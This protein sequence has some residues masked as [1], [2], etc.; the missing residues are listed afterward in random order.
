ML[1]ILA[2][3][4]SGPMQA[5]DRI[6]FRQPANSWFEAVPVGNG[7][8]GAMVFGGVPEERLQL[9]EDTVWAGKRM[10]RV[11][12]EGRAAVTKTRQLLKEGKIREAEEAAQAMLA[13]PV[14]MPPYQPL[15]DLK[16][17]FAHPGTPSAYAR[18]L[19]LDTAIA[20]TVYRIADTTYTREV[21][22]SYPSQAIVVRLSASRQNK[23]SF[24]VSMSRENA[25]ATAAGSR[26]TL[27]GMAMPV[28]ERSA[29]EPKTGVRFHAVT[30]VNQS[31][32]QIAVEG[33]TVLVTNAS[34]ATLRVVAATDYFAAPGVDWKVKCQAA[35]LRSA[36]AYHTLRAR[37]VEDYQRL[38]RRVSLTFHTAENTRVPTDVRLDNVKKGAYDP[39]LEALYFQFA[40]YLLIASSRP[41]SL[42]ANLQGIWND[43]LTPP[44]ESK[45]TININTE[46]NYWPA[47]P[48][49]LAE[50][51]QPLF[52][53]LD[54]ARVEGRKVARQMYGARGFVVHHNTD[55]WG[56]AVPIDGIRSGVWPTGGAWLSLHLW[57][58]YAFSRDRGFLTR[59]AYPV[60]KEASEFFLDYL[61]SD[62][63]GRLLS[64]PSI[65][66]ENR[67]RTA[68]GT[69]GSIVM[70]PEM[71]TRIV[72]ELFLRTAEAAEILKL[73]AALR[74]QL[75]TARAKLPPMKT[76]KHGQLMEWLED[77]DEPEPGHRHISHLF[78]LHPGN[79]ITPRGTPELT[80]AARVSLERRLANGG[81]QTGWSQAWVI[82]FWARLLEGDK[83]GEALIGLL[84]KST[85]PNLLDTHPAGRSYVF[86]IDGN[87]GGAAGVAEMLLQSQNG[88][89]E[90]L[91]ALPSF[92][93]DGEITGLRARGGVEAGIAWKNG[94]ARQVMLLSSANQT[95]SVRL[96]GSAP[97]SVK[98]TAGVPKILV[99]E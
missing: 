11:N 94:R 31:G 92:W 57:E 73:D 32:G 84:R 39:H 22:A 14:R 64:G 6:W 44:W 96:P 54:K 63:Q 85:G 55:G 26:V 53:L 8:L 24:R 86:Q 79:R 15:G 66:P 45:Y 37:H 20:R 82:N 60:L 17:G 3:V 71:D 87:F 90:I 48:L 40:R 61:K 50:L 51:H 28:G 67:Y 49:N 62:E 30:D 23:L 47:E 38:Y 10:D 18:E 98:L 2:L 83:A 59:R 19:S 97:E 88:E 69:V 91:P 27:T 46:M 33:D 65:S 81:G 76:G 77:H 75:Q 68:D 21:F 12:P 56:H 78:G 43:S 25:V 80:K 4:A 99:F 29:A 16:I 41:G 95:V 58:H 34:E 74:Q 42:P 5:E 35:L 72:D 52:D 13:K 36:A 93:P 7:R 70:G 89:L 9:N 1:W